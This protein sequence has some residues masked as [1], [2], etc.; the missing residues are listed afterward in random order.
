MFQQG[1]SHVD[2]KTLKTMLLACEAAD[3]TKRRFQDQSAQF[4]EALDALFEYIDSHRLEASDIQAIREWAASSLECRDGE[5]DAVFRTTAFRLAKTLDRV[6]LAVEK[7]NGP[8]SPR[9]AVL[10]S[11]MS[12]QPRSFHRLRSSARWIGSV[13]GGVAPQDLE[14]LGPIER[15]LLEKQNKTLWAAVQA[16]A[17]TL[18]KIANDARQLEADDL[19]QLLL[20]S[21]SDTR[22][23][24][25]AIESLLPL[26]EKLL[27]EYPGYAI[28][29]R[30]HECTRLRAVWN[31]IHAFG[32]EDS[33][34]RITAHMLT[35][36][37]Q[38]GKREDAVTTQ[39]LRQVMEKPGQPV[40]KYVKIIYLKSVAPESEK[41]SQK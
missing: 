39:W 24:T 23:F 34:S 2:V 14:S 27:L 25:R 15:F 4:Y 40:D 30:Y 37:A 6:W 10:C 17:L 35:L 33:H 11:A 29:D 1:E 20:D 7:E 5:H 26:S 36:I 18:E 8:F 28:P 38:F 41:E 19:T 31:I 3:D 12:A 22:E 21:R 9:H 13:Q 16:D 32:G